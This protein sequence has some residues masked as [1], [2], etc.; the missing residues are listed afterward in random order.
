MSMRKIALYIVLIT[1]LGS[2][3][4]LWQL[5]TLPNSLSA[6]EV[7]FGYNAYSILKTGKDEFGHYLP[8][9]FQSF[10]DYKNPVF[11]YILIPFIYLRGLTDW[12]IRFP[13][14]LSGIAVIPLMFFITQKLTRNI[15]LSLITAVFASISPWLI[16]YSRVAIEMEM[17]LFLTLLGV[18]LLLEARNRAHFYPLS[19]FVFGLSFYTYHSSK[20]WTIF[21]GLVMFL[22]SVKHKSRLYLLI[23]TFIFIVMTIPYFELLISAKIGLRPY[24]ISVFSNQ[25]THIEN[26]KMVQVDL[27]ND[28]WEGRLVHN[29]RLVYMNQ[30]IN[31]FLSVLNPQI[32]FSQSQYNHT[33]AIRLI[34]LW[35]L[36]LV[37]IGAV[38]LLR[39][40]S[41]S[42][43]I[44]GWLIIG[45]IPGGLTVLPPYDRRIL[46][47]SFP[48][49]FLAALGL[50]RVMHFYKLNHNYQTTL[51]K[52][53]LLAV[54][55]VSIYIYL[56][57]YFIHGPHTVI[58]TWGNGSK[59]V[60]TLVG[61]LKHQ[62]EQVVVSIKSNQPL[63]FFL[64]Y[65]KYPP[66]KYLD[67]GGTISGGYLDE[68]NK[69]DKYRFKFIKG[70]DL[71]TKYL[72]VWHTAENQP[73]LT[74]L[75]T[76]F[77]TEGK[78][79][80]HIGIYNPQAQNCQSV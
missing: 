53:A 64:Y 29:R 41:M 51:G 36:P 33:P 71:S 42:V 58:D 14:A 39:K 16:Q 10:D 28:R 59:D 61:K 62:Y 24:A 60:V 47:N 15:R 78:P 80:V 50:D 43:F 30:A 17:A 49:L 66:E 40:R 25:E 3:V 12:V 5:D 13:S 38:Y 11:G 32:L 67:E 27:T 76:V 56:H 72:Y 9:Y 45:F 68:R 37:L 34:Y 65:E 1:L 46:L 69:F 20:V 4:R 52:V 19:A 2:V 22:L 21:F 6:D 75:Q 7:A 54:I 63:I 31:G 57:N 35:Q 74:P 77:I 44:F 23:G 26:A 18:W 8:L 70:D 48:L 79:L 55:F 73:C